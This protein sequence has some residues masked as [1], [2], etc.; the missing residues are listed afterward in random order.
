MSAYRFRS[1]P[2]ALRRAKLDNLALVPANLLPFKAKWQAM[3][4]SLPEGSVLILLP[5]PNT[6]TTKTLESVASLLKGHGHRVTTLSA[7]HF[8]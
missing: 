8:R 2:R 1:P 3:A 5:R 7:E 4:N 6:A